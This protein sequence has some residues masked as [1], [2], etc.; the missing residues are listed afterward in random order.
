[1]GQEVRVRVLSVDLDSKRVGLSM[2]SESANTG[3]DEGSYDGDEGEGGEIAAPQRRVHFKRG[4]GEERAKLKVRVGDKLTGTVSN[5]ADFGAFI[6]I[7]EGTDALLHRSKIEG[8]GERKRTA[9][10]V[11][12]AR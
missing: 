5:L 11:A 12:R 4:R 3:G 10:R 7:A 2:R 6:T 1:M 8:D 9:A